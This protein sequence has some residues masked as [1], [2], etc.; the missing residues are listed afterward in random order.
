[1]AK[2]ESAV[3]VVSVLVVIATLS[4]MLLAFVNKTTKGPIEEN[5]K[6][7]VKKAIQLVLKDLPEYSV[8]DIAK[9]MEIDNSPIKY[10]PAI[11]KNDSIVGYAIV[12]MAPNG[13]SGEFPVMV[14]VDKSG[15]IIDTYVL[16]HKE[17][18]GL[19]SK[20]KDEKFKSQFRKRDL[21]GTK[22]KVKKDGGDID[23]ITAATISSRAFTASVLRA[24]KADKALMEGEK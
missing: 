6:M 7:E 5:K 18:P 19:G 24:L 3:R 1:M 2:E 15:K 16:E 4:A 20:M 12:A 10:Y 14:G 11:T 9:T 21:N 17:T 13:F 8:A 23:A 22:W